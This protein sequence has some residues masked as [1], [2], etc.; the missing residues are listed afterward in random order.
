MRTARRQRQLS[1]P[2]AQ[3]AQKT[4]AGK[5]FKVLK[6]VKVYRAA[7]PTPGLLAQSGQALVPARPTALKT[8]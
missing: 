5:V 6:V 7:H 8:W 4:A 3:R 1:A 2:R